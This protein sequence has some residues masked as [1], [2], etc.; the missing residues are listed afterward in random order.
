MPQILNKNGWR[1]M[2]Q[3]RRQIRSVLPDE[4]LIVSTSVLEKCITL[5]V[6][7]DVDNDP[8]PDALAQAR[9]AVEHLNT[10]LDGACVISLALEE[11]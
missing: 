9:A 4:I 8:R 6:K 10:R 3:L 7:V 5:V 2:A 1:S 11:T